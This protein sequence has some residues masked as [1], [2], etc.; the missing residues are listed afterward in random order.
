MESKRSDVGV[1]GEPAAMALGAARPMLELAAA[2]FGSL[3]AV[4]GGAK[5]AVA[6][7]GIAGRW[8]SEHRA[9]LATAHAG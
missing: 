2:G 1:A 8:W 4:A 7:A 5:L 6:A 3:A 9:R